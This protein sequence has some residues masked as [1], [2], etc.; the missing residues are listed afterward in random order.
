[1]FG[2]LPKQH[3]RALFF[4]ENNWFWKPITDETIVTEERYPG[5]EEDCCQSSARGKHTAMLQDRNPFL[6]YPTSLPKE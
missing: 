6:E 2:C 3:H 1:V 4:Y 5:D